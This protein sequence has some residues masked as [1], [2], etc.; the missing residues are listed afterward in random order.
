MK[1]PWQ[2]KDDLLEVA[3]DELLERYLA[4]DDEE[5]KAAILEEY[6][7]I[8]EQTLEHDKVRATGR[9]DGKTILGT[10]TTLVLAG[11]T[12]IFEQTD[13]LHSKVVPLWLRRR[14]GGN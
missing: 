4:S 8:D 11:A 14:F 5:E 3:K 10:V 7:H 1:L 2:K 6:M 13:V 9:I 12:L